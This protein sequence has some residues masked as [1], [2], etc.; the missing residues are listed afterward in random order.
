LTDRPIDQ[1]APDHF[2]V[3]AMLDG[4]GWV[5][6]VFTSRERPRLSFEDAAWRDGRHSRTWIV[7]GIRCASFAEAEQALQRA[8]VLT[9]EE[10]AMLDELSDE[11][12]AY[13][14]FYDDSSVISPKSHERRIELDY[15]LRS[16]GLLEWKD[17]KVRRRPQRP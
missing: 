8:P 3:S 6:R 10:Q 11:W 12:V 4:D 1:P 7:D 2:E 13:A 16:K 14:D 17:G 15:S 9:P 5:G